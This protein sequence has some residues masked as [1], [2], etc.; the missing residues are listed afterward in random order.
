MC[1]FTTIGKWQ[2][3][4]SFSLY[5]WVNKYGTFPLGHPKILTENFAKISAGN[6]PYFGMIK[7]KVIPP[8]GLFHPV[9]P[10][11]SNGKLCFPLCRTCCNTQES[12]E[13]NHSNEERALLGTWPTVEFDKA[14]QLG[15]QVAETTSGVQEIYEVWHYKKRSDTL[16]R[17]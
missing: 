9:L 11:R 14:L 10:Y 2:P 3:I 8:R 12:E 16:F 5:P 13:C 4:N 15:Y 1:H 17:S 6:L 7:A